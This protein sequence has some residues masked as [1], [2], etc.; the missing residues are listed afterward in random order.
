[1]RLRILIKIQ[2]FAWSMIAVL[3]VH[4]LACVLIR[5][6]YTNKIC[7]H[8]E[9]DICSQIYPKF[10]PGTIFKFESLTW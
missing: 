6:V 7:L 5:Q 3:R 1:M 2:C 10:Y 8:V 9:L 4:H